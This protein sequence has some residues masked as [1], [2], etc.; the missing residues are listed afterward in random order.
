[1][2][3]QTLPKWSGSSAL[4]FS[5]PSLRLLA[6][7]PSPPHPTPTRPNLPA[8]PRWRSFAAAPNP[9]PPQPPAA[10]RWRSFAAAPNPNPPNLLRL[11]AGAPSPPHPTP[12]RPDLLA[13]P[14]W[15]SFAAAPPQPETQPGH[16]TG[17]GRV[18]HT[19]RMPDE[20]ET[21]TG[22]TDQPTDDELELE[23]YDIDHDGEIGVID[24][25][26]AQA[27]IGRCPDGRDRRGG[28]DQRRSRRG[29]A[30]DPRRFRQRLRRRR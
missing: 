26:R 2:A 20:S 23:T 27:R 13:A 4:R 3:S 12:T 24:H 18:R 1:M 10:P 6:G 8:A 11:L 25:E 22:S 19:G 5:S 9:N 17:P 30:Q 29:S 7:A 14:R 15:R 16:R 21:S 28:R